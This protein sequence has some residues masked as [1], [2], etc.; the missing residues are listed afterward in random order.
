MTFAVKNKGRPKLI[1]FEEGRIIKN[2]IVS[3]SRQKKT[4]QPDA[5]TSPG[6][7]S[8][9]EHHTTLVLSFL[10]WLLMKVA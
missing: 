4:A 1:R 10:L 5:K 7:T 6:D 2:E 8:N 9:I 3:M